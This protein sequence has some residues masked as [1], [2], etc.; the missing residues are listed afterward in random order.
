M[1][2]IIK[3]LIIFA[4]IPISHIY[5]ET[6]KEGTYINGTY[7]TKEFPGA[8]FYLQVRFVT[9][10]SNKI[11]YCLEPFTNLNTST[12]YNVYEDITTYDKISPE[13]IDKIK[14]AIYYGYQSPN[15]VE[16][17]WYAIT[18]LVIWQLVRPDR[19]IYFTDTLNGN[20]VN[21]YDQ[22]I[23]S[24]YEDIN[25]HYQIPSFIKNYE[26]NLNESLEIP[27]LN[28]SYKIISS[29]IEY[30]KN[31][32]LYLHKIK[33]SATIKVS[34]NTNRI[35]NEPFII[36]ESRESQDA[37]KI[38]T[39][40]QPTWDINILVHKGNININLDKDEE[41]KESK[42]DVCYDIYEEERKIDII[43][44]N[45]KTTYKTPDLPYGEYTIKQTKPGIGYDPITE[46]YKV[47]ISEKNEQPEIT[48]ISKLIKN[49]LKLHK[50]YC[51]DDKCLDEPNAKFII[52][53]ID[54]ELVTEKVTD[55][56][57]NFSITLPYGTY[58]IKQTEGYQDY[59]ISRPFS[60]KI[61]DR[62][63]KI[64]KELRDNYL[65]KEEIIPP[66][67]G[68]EIN[69]MRTSIISLVAV[70]LIILSRKRL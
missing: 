3:L 63:S 54:Q 32:S 47:T 59:E 12:N 14:L 29:T 33:E 46:I 67:T 39:V 27:G 7:I 8:K 20:K 53:D 64:E 24:L 9:N 69:S 44:A 49:T 38:G 50:M 13:I 23:S 28:E 5:A 43:C 40:S 6:L 58:E 11:V 31:I 42:Y 34:K 1:K 17:K 56:K 19:P 51:K 16:D 60:I 57:G 55:A 62:T 65:I 21:K 36:Y 68:V 25:N 2:K 41:S 10:E 18:Q 52:L 48:I 66:D 35:D 26:V 61:I 4:I 30:E 45:E 37:I 70:I 22:E 15:R